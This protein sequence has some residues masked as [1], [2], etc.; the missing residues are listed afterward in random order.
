MLCDI[1]CA[2]LPLNK[3]KATCVGWENK[4]TYRT[5]NYFWGINKS[6]NTRMK[7]KKRISNNSFMLQ[8]QLTEN[9]FVSK[10]VCGQILYTITKNFYICS[11]GLMHQR[12]CCFAPHPQ[13]SNLP[14][15]LVQIPLETEI[16]S[17]SFLHN[18]LV[19]VL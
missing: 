5:L 17:T 15:F 9:V 7:A 8:F 16:V 4:Y 11:V 14:M 10:L 19:F 6:C 12:I 3:A 13:A 18:S 1:I 2:V